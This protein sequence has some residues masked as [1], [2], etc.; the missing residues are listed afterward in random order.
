MVSVVD[1]QTPKNIGLGSCLHEATFSKD[2]VKVFHEAG[3]VLSYEY[4]TGYYW[5]SRAY[6]MDL[7]TGTGV[8]QNLIPGRFI[9]YS[10]EKI[11]ILHETLDQKDTLHATQIAAWQQG[12]PSAPVLDQIKPLAKQI[13]NVPESMEL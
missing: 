3:H 6:L 11:D 2:L 5:I 13:L 9:H 7:E 4:S 12:T 10:A 8:S 1:S